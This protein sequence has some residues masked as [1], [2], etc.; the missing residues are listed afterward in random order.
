M[1]INC[2]CSHWNHSCW[3]KE[4]K[5]NIFHM[6]L[7]ILSSLFSILPKKTHKAQQHNKPERENCRDF[8]NLSQLVSFC[9][10]NKKKKKI[11]KDL[12]LHHT[13]QLGTRKINVCYLQFWYRR[14]CL[15]VGAVCAI[16]LN[17]NTEKH[18]TLLLLCRLT[19]ISQINRINLS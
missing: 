8:P 7:H 3:K 18:A 12:P 6:L 17:Q 4:R 13:L 15:H 5:I 16:R 19:E 11:T 14:W 9:N 10:F 2:R 1:R